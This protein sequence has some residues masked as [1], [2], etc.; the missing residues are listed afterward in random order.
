MKFGAHMSTAGGVWKALQ[1]ATQIG[2]EI[3]QVFVKNNM[4]W[5]GKPYAA[6]DLALYANEPAAQK[7]ASVFGHAGYLINL[8]APA[9][10]NRDKSLQ[11]LIQEIQLATDLGLPFLVMHPGAHLGHGEKKA[12][13][14]IVAGLDEVF[15]ATRGSPV[16]IALEKTTRQGS[17]LGPEV[18]QFAAIYYRARPPKRLRAGP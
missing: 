12:L 17:W 16:R 8:G 3:C 9:C 1:R 10:A 11:S 2:A 13:K 5:F 6:Q 18:K 15:R 14:Q 7:L 4:Q